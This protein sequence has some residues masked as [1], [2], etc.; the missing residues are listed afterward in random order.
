MAMLEAVGA[1]PQNVNYAVK[2]SHAVRL[3]QNVQGLTPLSSQG[4][5]PENAV[6]T[7]ESAIAM[8]LIY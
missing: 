6:K 3:L 2:V 8:V 5:R 7:V 4:G 1:V